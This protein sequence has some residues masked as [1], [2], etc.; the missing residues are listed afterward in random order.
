MAKQSITVRVE[1][2]LIRWFREETH[3]PLGQAVNEALRLLQGRL[4]SEQLQ[5]QIDRELAEGE[6]LVSPDDLSYWERLG[7]G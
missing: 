7:D 4:L 1:P 3:L 2:E 5:K 6:A